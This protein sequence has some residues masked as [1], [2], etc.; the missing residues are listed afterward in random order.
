MVPVRFAASGLA[1]A[2]RPG[3]A[4]APA[5]RPTVA[6]AAAPRPVVCRK[7]RRVTPGTTGRP[8]LPRSVGALLT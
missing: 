6:A 2:L 1:A 5:P 4:A 7:F 3:A 8:G